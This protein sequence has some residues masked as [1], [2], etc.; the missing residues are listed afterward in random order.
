MAIRTINQRSLIVNNLSAL[1]AEQKARPINIK[2]L[3]FGLHLGKKCTTNTKM[4]AL[5]AIKLNPIA[6][7]FNALCYD[8]TN[9]AIH[10]QSLIYDT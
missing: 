1:L 6:P 5:R 4:T 2:R 7:G 3:P 8:I 10:R 9:Q